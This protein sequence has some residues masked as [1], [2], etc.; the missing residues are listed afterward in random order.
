[1]VAGGEDEEDE[2]VALTSAGDTGVGGAST[3]KIFAREKTFPVV[4]LQPAVRGRMVAVGS[5]S[6]MP[7]PRPS[8][9]PSKDLACTAVMGGELGGENLERVVAS[10]VVEEVD[11]MRRMGVAGRGRLEEGRVEECGVA[12]DWM[13]REFRRLAVPMGVSVGALRRFARDCWWDGSASGVGSFSIL[14]SS[15]SA[16]SG[17][18]IELNASKN[19]PG[20][21]SRRIKSLSNTSSCCCRL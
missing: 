7:Q 3:L 18:S 17:S 13:R 21:E 9:S 20:Q 1:M 5:T 11:F 16:C 12:V 10:V 2:V 15:F 8:S 14:G 4:V 6:S 19:S